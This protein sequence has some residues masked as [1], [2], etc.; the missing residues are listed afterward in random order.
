MAKSGTGG[1]GNAKRGKTKRGKTKRGNAKRGKATP[2]SKGRKQRASRTASVRG[3]LSAGTLTSLRREL[4][5]AVPRRPDP[6]VP[7]D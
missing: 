7:T 5:G 1:R 3:P 2:A 4:L 6:D